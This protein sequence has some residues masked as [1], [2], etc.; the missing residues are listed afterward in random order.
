MIISVVSAE[1]MKMMLKKSVFSGAK[2]ITSEIKKR[3]IDT[4]IYME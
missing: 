1:K 4:Y 2:K 3:A